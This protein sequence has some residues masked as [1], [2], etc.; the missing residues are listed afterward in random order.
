MVDHL[1]P[2]HA[3]AQVTVETGL[4]I[5]GFIGV[6]ML[7]WLFVW[8]LFL[9][10]GLSHTLEWVGREVMTTGTF[11]ESALI[12]KAGEYSIELDPEVDTLEIV[13][14]DA[15]GTAITYS[16]GDGVE[17]SFGNLISVYIKKEVRTGGFGEWLSTWED[18]MRFPNIEGRWT[19]VAQRNSP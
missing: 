13:V 19:G 3:R 18:S 8:V 2:R 15:E 7:L 14:T 1:R 11:D 12:A 10:F 9:N 5:T 17:V 6:I 4:V 16:W